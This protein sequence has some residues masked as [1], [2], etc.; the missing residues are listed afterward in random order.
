[1]P[2]DNSPETQA[3]REKA[4]AMGLKFHP[5]TGAAKLNKLMADFADRQMGQ[6]P[7]AAVEPEPKQK[8]EEA[9]T[10]MS[11]TQV[12]TP[13]ANKKTLTPAQLLEAQKKEQLRLIRVIVHCNNEEKSDW[14]GEV[15]KVGNR[16]V[17][18][19]TRFI[20]FD[21]E[22]G[23]HIEQIILDTLRTKRCQKWRNIRMPSGETQKQPYTVPEFTIEELPPLTRE[24]LKALADDQRARG[25]IDA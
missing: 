16:L 10:P 13:Q 23:W 18:S 2:F 12:A 7:G 17:G 15:F 14:Q 22:E 3:L 21:N 4:K 24:Q 1:M 5:S 11:E 6:S 19:V 25:A 20:P 8:T 9:Q